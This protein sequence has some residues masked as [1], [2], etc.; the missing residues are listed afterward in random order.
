VIEEE[1]HG[2]THELWRKVI[3]KAGPRGVKRNSGVEVG[4]R[5]SRTGAGEVKRDWTSLFGRREASSRHQV[6][7]ARKGGNLCRRTFK[8]GVGR[9]HRVLPGS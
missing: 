5:K 7:R 8:G 4:R 6:S 2:N 3:S 9:S 1:V